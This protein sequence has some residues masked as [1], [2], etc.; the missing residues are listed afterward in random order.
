MTTT[1]THL[2]EIAD[3]APSGT[4]CVECLAAGHRD[5][6]HLRVCQECGHVGCCDN[7]PGKHATAHYRSVAHP[8]I[9]SFEPGEGWYYCYPDDLMFELEGAPPAPTHP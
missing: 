4:G 1:C 2:D 8:I 7:S 6:V 5:W 9:R 3:V